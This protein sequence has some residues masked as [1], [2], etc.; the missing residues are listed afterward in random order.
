MQKAVVLGLISVF[1]ISV[2]SGLGENETGRGFDC[3]NKQVDKAPALSFEETVFSL[4]ALAD[5]G[6]KQTKLKD[7]LI[8]FSQ[9]DGECWPKGGCKIKETAMALLALQHIR[10]D[11]EKA[12]AFLLK[13]NGSTIDLDWFLEVDS[14]SETICKISY[15]NANNSIT[16]GADKKIN[17]NAGSCL[18]LA[19]GNYW[20]KISQNCLGKEFTINCDKDFVSS[21][22]FQ[23]RGSDVFH[24]PSATSSGAAKN[25]FYLK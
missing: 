5:N 6:D 2:V 14:A 7:K 21:V 9:N 18:S 17:Q 11:T 22:F 4:I 10:A 13:Q 24:L 23:R 15:D 19:N 25:S 3:L 1:L 16:I 12:E 8:S 20:L